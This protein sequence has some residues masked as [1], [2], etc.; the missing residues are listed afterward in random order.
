MKVIIRIIDILEGKKKFKGYF[1]IV[2]DGKEKL[3][4]RR[5][6]MLLSTKFLK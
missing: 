6:L 2:E 3:I 4:L 5:D 1:S